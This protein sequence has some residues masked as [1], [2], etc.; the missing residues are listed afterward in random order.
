LFPDIPAFAFVVDF[1]LLFITDI[2]I[3]LHC[4]QRN[5]G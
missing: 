3:V 4:L 1:C 2:L 5:E